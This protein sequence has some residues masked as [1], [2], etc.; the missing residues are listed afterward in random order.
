M[1]KIKALL[2]SVFA[3]LANKC[4]PVSFQN[5][6]FDNFDEYD[7]ENFDDEN[8]NEMDEYSKA[9][10]PLAPKAA[11][12]SVWVPKNSY[13]TIRVVNGA[14]AAVIELFNSF[15]TIA[16]VANAAQFAGL[17]PFKFANRAAANANSTVVWDYNGNLVITSAGAVV[18]TIS[19]NEIPY[20]V[21]LKTLCFFRIKIESIKMAFTNDPQLDNALYFTEK[22]FLGK[23][24]ENNMIPRQYLKDA[25]FQSKQVTIPT[26]GLIIDGE[27]GIYTTVNASETMS[28]TFKVTGVQKF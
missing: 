25:Q 18:C 1:K 7:D 15:Y 20:Q 12:R 16:D 3:F 2:F 19:C 5:L 11:P 8:Y 26:N 14:A 9:G 6:V 4:K 23:R 21:L 22:T 13:F 28:F 24:T 17:N 10:K 27:R